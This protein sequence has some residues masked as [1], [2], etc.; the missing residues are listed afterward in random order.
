MHWMMLLAALLIGLL[1]MTTENS[2]E[3]EWSEIVPEGAEPEKIAGG[4]QFLEG[5]TWTSRDTLVFSDIPADTLYEYSNAGRPVSFRRPSGHSNGN[6]LDAEGRLVTCHHGT[7]CITRT[8]KDGSVVVLADSYQGKRL[9]SPNDITGKSNGDLYFSDPPYGIDPDPGELG[10]NGVY[11]Y[12][13]SD[14]SLTLVANDFDRPNGLAFSPDEKRLYIGDSRRKHIRAFEA[15]ED[16]TLGEGPVFAEIDTS[17]PGS[18]DG[19]RVDW[20]G[21]L[22]CAGSGGVQIYAPSG[23]HLGWIPFPEVPSNLAWGDADGK[24]LYVTAR[25]GLYRI[26]LNIGGKKIPSVSP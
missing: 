12:S 7:R 11:R 1:A 23:K 14:G 16:G 19:M 6:A 25:T 15:R 5:P 24:T 21:N 4:F 2:G 18:P 10:F 17:R 20:R 8:E 9:N 22:Y 26:R 13:A 3:S